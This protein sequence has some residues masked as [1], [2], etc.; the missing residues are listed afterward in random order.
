MKDGYV[1]KTRL[2]VFTVTLNQPARVPSSR[3]VGRHQRKQ[4][5]V[6]RV[7]MSP[8]FSALLLQANEAGISGKLGFLRLMTHLESRVVFNNKDF[9]KTKTS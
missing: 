4:M 2:P 9:I 1:L 5:F 7:Q 3:R 8:D 6:L